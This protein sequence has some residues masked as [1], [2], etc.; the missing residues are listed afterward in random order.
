MVHVWFVDGFLSEGKSKQ[1]RKIRKMFIRADTGFFSR[2]LFNSLESLFG[3]YLANVKLKNLDDLLKVKDLKDV[4]GVK[5]FAICEFSNKA[6]SRQCSRILKAMRSVK[7]YIEISY[8]GK[9]RVYGR[10]T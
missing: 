6:K 9:T 5:K 10:G 2:E 1:P 8:M 7:E 3:D 4:E